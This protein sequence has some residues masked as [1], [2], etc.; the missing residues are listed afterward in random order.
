MEPRMLG[1]A[2]REQECLRPRA[3]TQLRHLQ[4]Q[5]TRSVCYPK[6]RSYGRQIKTSGRRLPQL[7]RD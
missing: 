1:F 5:T 6:A 7:W 3:M 2:E 4:I